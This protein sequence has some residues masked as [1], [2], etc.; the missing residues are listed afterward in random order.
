MLLSSIVYPLACGFCQ[1]VESNLFFF[2]FVQQESTIYDNNILG[3]GQY[4][5]FLDSR[6][7]S[8]LK[9]I[10]SWNVNFWAILT[11]IRE[12]FGPSCILRWN[13]T[14][15]FMQNLKV[16]NINFCVANLRMIQ[17]SIAKCTR[18]RRACPSFCRMLKV[19]KYQ[20][21]C[22]CFSSLQGGVVYSNKVTTV[23]PIYASD[24]LKQEHGY[25]LHATLNNHKYAFFST[26]CSNMT[27]GIG[28]AQ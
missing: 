20:E 27:Q 25:G 11:A 28:D 14:I 9:A 1:H 13:T 23:S 10:G 22:W 15:S 2:K 12:D 8:C 4:K 5:R 3:C 24:L 21:S 7:Y 16:S 17:M 26:T 18:E 6:K 19:V